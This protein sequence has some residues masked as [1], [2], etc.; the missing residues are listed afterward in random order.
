M[1]T[2]SNVTRSPGL[3]TSVMTVIVSPVETLYC[4][5]P[6]LMTA[7][8]LLPSCSICLV[9]HPPPPCASIFNTASAIAMPLAT[10]FHR[11]LP[12]QDPELDACEPRNCFN[13]GTSGGEVSPNISKVWS[14]HLHCATTRLQGKAVFIAKLKTAAQYEWPA[15]YSNRASSTKLGASCQPSHS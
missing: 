5:P 15:R 12:P 4:L 7:N 8:N 10:D 6:V 3:P 13:S 1:R 9:F 11:G 2:E 14:V